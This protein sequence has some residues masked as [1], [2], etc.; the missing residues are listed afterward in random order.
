MKRV[1]N[2]L[3]GAT[4]YYPR[5]PFNVVTGS[6]FWQEDA[7]KN[8][9]ETKMVPWGVDTNFYVPTDR[10]RDDY[11]L[12]MSR[13]HPSKGLDWVLDIAEILT[14]TP[15]KVHGSMEF[16]DHAEYGAKY[17]DRIKGLPNVE[18]VRL[19]IDSTYHERK[20]ELLQQARCLLLPI[21]QGECFGLVAA[22]A[23]CCGLPVICTPAGALPEVVGKVGIVAKS[24][25]ELAQALLK[26][27]FPT[28]SEC[29]KQGERWSWGRAA[30]G[31]L[32]LYREVL[33]GESW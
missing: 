11:V 23:L 14:D 27:E 8:G 7:R 5:P 22:E 26:G 10:P 1:V 12:W 28:P 13:C 16:A 4:Y 30:E 15:F 6:S 24:K 29:R 21:Q 2:T 32:E 33:K 3:N 17:L 9:L 19:P 31:Y 18:F 25:G 20:R